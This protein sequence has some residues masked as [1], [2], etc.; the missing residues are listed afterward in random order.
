[1]HGVLPHSP[2]HAELMADFEERVVEGHVCRV[3]V[4]S[5]ETRLTSLFAHVLMGLSLLLIPKPLGQI[6]TSVLDG[7]FLYMAVSSLEGN[8]LFERLL[9]LCTEQ[10]V[11]EF[12]MNV[13]ILRRADPMYLP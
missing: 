6:P 2:L 5:R 12:L 9:L 8:Q 7:L 11:C 4:K 3:V 10:E 13:V 1:M